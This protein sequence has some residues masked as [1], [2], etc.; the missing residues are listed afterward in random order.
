MNIYIN[1][2]IIYVSMRNINY[3]YSWNFD[4]YSITLRQLKK[5]IKVRIAAFILKY[6]N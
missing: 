5:N 3:L 1:R 2:Y 4:F 6:D